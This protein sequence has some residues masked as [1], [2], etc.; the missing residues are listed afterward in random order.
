MKLKVV[1]IE[2][3]IMA[4]ARMR[5]LLLQYDSE[6]EIIAEL[7]SVEDAV[8]WFKNGV[9]PDL[10][11]MDIQLAD[12][13]SFNIFDEVKVDYPIIFTTAY[14]EY[15][16]RA[17]KVNSIDYLLKPVSYSDLEQAMN[18]FKKHLGFGSNQ[19]SLEVIEKVRQMLKKDYKK[20]FTARVGEHIKSILIED[21]SFFHSEGKGT[22]ITTVEKRQ[23]LIDYS[24]EAL[25]ELLDPD[26]FF[27][28]NRQYIIKHSAIEDIMAYSQSRLKVRLKNCDDEK[29]LISRDKVGSFKEWLEI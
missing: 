17:F 3:E 29:I 7:D 13:I 2:D 12:G 24:L 25:T 1:I 27:R 4:A 26:M 11:L 8:K 16:I 20:R 28:I 14:Q 22:F 5:D 6:I 19:L 15:A 10:V 18:A 9:V 21:I 23:Y